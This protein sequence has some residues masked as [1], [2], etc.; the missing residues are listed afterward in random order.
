RPGRGCG[1]GGSPGPPRRGAAA[2]GCGG[3]RCRGGSF[4]PSRSESAVVAP[5]RVG[6][7]VAIANVATHRLGI[8]IRGRSPTAAAAGHDLDDFAG[9]DRVLRRLAHVTRG[10]V[11]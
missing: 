11:G 7:D 3:T 4:E 10:A 5:R 8:P 2:R 9:P 1:A 6:R